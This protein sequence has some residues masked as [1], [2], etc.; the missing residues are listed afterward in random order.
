MENDEKI[1]DLV[2][3]LWIQLFEDGFKE[4]NS[5]E[6]NQKAVIRTLITFLV[7]KNK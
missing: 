4:M 7:N 1:E 5:G 6:T 3:G 2:N